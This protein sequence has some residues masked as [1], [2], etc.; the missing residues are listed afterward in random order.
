MVALFFR[1]IDG[2]EVFY[3]VEDN[4]KQDWAEHARLN[5]GTIRVEDMDGNV[6]WSKAKES[7]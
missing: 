6:L 3:P 2:N 5:P 1:E 7:N 4:L